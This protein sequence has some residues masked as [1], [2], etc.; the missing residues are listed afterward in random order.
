VDFILQ[1][2]IS[3]RQEGQQDVKVWR[4]ILEHI[5]LNKGSHGWRGGGAGPG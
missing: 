5:S 1:I 4:H 2:N 3:V